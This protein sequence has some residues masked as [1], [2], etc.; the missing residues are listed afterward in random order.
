[1]TVFNLNCVWTKDALR[2]H[3]GKVN[4]EL[5]YHSQHGG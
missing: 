4:R 3:G 1:M 5:L 2:K